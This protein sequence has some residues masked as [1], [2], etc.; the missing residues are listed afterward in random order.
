MLGAWEQQW[1]ARHGSIDE[2]THDQKDAIKEYLADMTK[3]EDEGLYWKRQSKN[4]TI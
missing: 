4:A 3:E 1:I 2:L